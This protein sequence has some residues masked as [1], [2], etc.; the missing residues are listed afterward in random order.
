VACVC[1]LGLGG[2]KSIIL[3]AL[4]EGGG[5]AAVESLREI[6]FGNV[7]LT[8]IRSRSTGMCCPRSDASAS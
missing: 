5:M 8:R 1:Y 2:V 7:P 4:P 3:E 6:A